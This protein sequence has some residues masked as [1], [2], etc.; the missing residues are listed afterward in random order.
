MVVNGVFHSVIITIGLT[1]HVSV[2]HVARHHWHS[3]HRVCVHVSR[4][5]ILVPVINILVV[6]VVVVIVT[7]VFVILTLTRGLLLKLVVR[8]SRS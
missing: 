6:G 1:H 4:V 2:L 8:G 3:V 5:R 7:V